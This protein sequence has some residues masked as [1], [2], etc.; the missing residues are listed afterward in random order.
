MS[1]HPRRLV[2]K[3]VTAASAL[4]LVVAPLAVTS[5]A[6]ANP[7]GTGVVINE[8]YI[9]G[10]SANAPYANKFIELYNPGT[11]AVSLSG[12]SLQYR[13]P[14]TTTAFTNVYPL[15]GTIAPGGHFLVSGS[16][17]GATGAALPTPDLVTGVN[18]GNGGGTLALSNATTTLNPG[19]G[20]ITGD[21]AIVDLLGWG[22]SNTS[23][24][25]V[26]PAP[27][28]TSDARS[29]NR[30]AFADTDSNV[31]DFSLSA[32]V[33]P[34]NSGGPVEPPGDPVP[35][36]IEEIQGTGAA[37]P[38]EGDL[39][40]TEG[41]VTAAYPTGNFNGFY[42]QTEGTGGAID[43]DTHTASDGLFVFGST[44]VPLVDI[45]DLVEVTGTV[46]EFGSMTELT[47]RTGGLQVLGT[48]TEPVTPATVG[49][50]A[51][52]AARETLEGMLVE[53]QGDFVV[54]DN[55]DLNAFGVVGLAAGTTPLRQPT[56]VAPPL[57]T[58]GDNSAY[59]A[60]VAD[61]AA[62]AVAL[63]DGSSLN[64]LSAANKATPLPY[65][66]VADPIRVGAAVTF[67]RP[68]V[69]DF[70]NGGWNFQPTQ[71]LT[72]ANAD[73]VQPATFEDTR[74]PAPEN[75]GGD[76]RL[77]SFNVL[78]YFTETGEDWIADGG[79]CTFFT[80]RDGNPITDNSC[81]DPGPR[82][83]ANDVNLQRQQAKIVSAV[84]A[85]DADVVSLEEIENSSHYGP[86]R[87]QALA[88]L[89]A[90]LN[91][92]A[93][94]D[95]WE[96]VPTPPDAADQTLED[97]IRTAF[98]YQP[99]VVE[100]VGD[101]VI[102]NDPAF[103][104]ARDPLAQAFKLAGGGD[105]S[106]FVA[107]VNHF[108]SK[109]SGSGVDADQGDGQ[110]ASNFSRTVQ[111]EALA[112]FADTMAG[113]AGTDRVFLLG[114]F[115][116]YTEE[117]PMQL[118]Y[119]AGYTDIGK[120]F[121]DE[122]TYLFDGVVG[123]LDHVLASPGA[124]D[125]VTG[126]DVWNI[127]S[128][129]SVA[130]EYSR[131]NYNATIFYQPDPYR[132]SDHDPLVVGVDLPNTVVPVDSTTTATAPGIRYGT[133]PTVDVTVTADPTATGV[134]EVR[135]G[136]VLRGS[137][138]L[139]DGA[140]SVSLSRLAMRPGSHSLTVSYLGNATTNPSSTTVTLQVAK[141]R[142]TMATSVAPDRIVVNRTRARVTVT[143]SSPAV[144]PNGVVRIRSGGSLIGEG[145]LS[146]GRVVIT[147][148]PF[149][150]VGTKQLKVRYNG[151]ANHEA[152]VE[153]IPVTVVRP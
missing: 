107:I 25:A 130:L 83:A 36:S 38:L 13:P 70:R 105:D 108:K 147:L 133:V 109:S 62:R 127:N 73:T 6:H 48:P 97:V 16:S 86:D 42:I 23:E 131:Y 150:S 37:S 137:G 101:A 55:F 121:T 54:T 34:E 122:S 7:A 17:N 142:P 128:V 67:E 66:T 117:D 151:D 65:L 72:A 56:D 116:S 35:A 95:K 74:T 76:V 112:D 77:A 51:T 69:L 52:D 3:A 71:Q 126:A 143:M 32:T 81:N 148:D 78:N 15:S 57:E 145:T 40:V 93:G 113:Q 90:A 61:N 58:G 30:T 149:R 21:P 75:V 139:V 94:S 100:P 29:L 140:V 41:V 106:T 120:A 22:T 18:P 44:F 63:D 85:L 28:A 2:V 8:A 45:G 50:P 49:Y 153:T 68:V 14:G 138:T 91:A 115:N 47:P 89:V 4:A 11:S 146:N 24:T 99:A 88:T 92:A 134:V 64:F 43:P 60:V 19:V 39:V 98:I 31:A 5:T 1:P 12:W 111:A 84:N 123:S 132:S 27:T 46:S 114:D 102:D 20:S 152:V 135:E 79:T 33:T 118:L 144:T 96:F 125:D 53:P 10:G 110:G 104:N 103:A 26:A 129:E 9:N 80:D 119:N 82:G 141:A 136:G 124:L 87:D 59:E